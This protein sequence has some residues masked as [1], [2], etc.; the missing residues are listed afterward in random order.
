MRAFIVTV[1]TTSV[2]HTYLAIARHAVDAAI[3]ANNSHPDVE[4]AV[5]VRPYRTVRP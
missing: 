2:S 3:D 1:R 5:T 4:C